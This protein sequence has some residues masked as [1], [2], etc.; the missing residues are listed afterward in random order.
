MYI[1]LEYSMFL[2]IRCEGPK[3]KVCGCRERAV[4]RITRFTLRQ[5]WPS[6]FCVS[7]WNLAGLLRLC[8]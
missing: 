1:N 3:L 2:N 8:C 7:Q 4:E 6:A 5:D